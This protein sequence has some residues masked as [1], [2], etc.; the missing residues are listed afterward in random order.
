[1]RRGDFGGESKYP[2]IPTF[3]SNRWGFTGKGG[4]VVFG[5]V[6]LGVRKGLGDKELG[7][8]MRGCESADFFAFF[9]VFLHFFA[10]AGEKWMK[11]VRFFA[12]VL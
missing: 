12:L 9:F 5:G 8:I 10:E 1:M 4:K 2:I 3:L 7:R 6:G 11:K